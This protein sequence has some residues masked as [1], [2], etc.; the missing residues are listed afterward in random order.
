VG[1][2][3]HVQLTGGVDHLARTL[4]SLA[5]FFALLLFTQWRVFS[6]LKFFLSWW[7]YSFPLAAM[8]IASFVMAE[9]THSAFLGAL[10]AVLL[11]GLSLLVAGLMVRTVLAV[12]RREICVDGH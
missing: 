9:R 1:F 7:A 3:A 8:T 6:R 10:A 11:A 5:G 2:I 12:R 4:Y